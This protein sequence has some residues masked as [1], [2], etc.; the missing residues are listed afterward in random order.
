MA[1]TAKRF[2]FLNRFARGRVERPDRPV[3]FETRTF[4]FIPLLTYYTFCSDTNFTY[5]NRKV[6]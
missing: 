1:A 6:G 2:Y 5:S 3:S 4:V